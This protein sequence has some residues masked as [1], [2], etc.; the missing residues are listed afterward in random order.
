MSVTFAAYYIL[1]NEVQSRWE[2]TRSLQEKLWPGWSAIRKVFVVDRAYRFEDS[3]KA[4]GDVVRVDLFDSRRHI[5]FSRAKNAGLD[6][7]KESQDV[8]W[9]LDAD[10]DSVVVRPPVVTPETSYSS[11]LCHFQ[12]VDESDDELSR[13]AAAGTLEARHFSRF[14]L[15]RAVFTKFRFDEK[16]HG[17]A[18]EDVDFHLNL[19]QRS[20]V[21]W[22]ESGMRGINLYHELGPRPG[23]IERLDLKSKGLA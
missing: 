5:L 18:G 10:A 4:L 6:W 23:N 13:R 3:V 8:E 22:S 2:R 17:Y 1:S 16:F 14:L 21:P 7:A 11:M 15:G 12:K 9:I 20:G 19:I